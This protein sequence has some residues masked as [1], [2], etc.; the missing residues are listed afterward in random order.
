LIEELAMNKVICVRPESVGRVFVEMEGGRSG[1]FDVTPY[2]RGEFF[3]ELKNEAY[4][5][6]VR[7]FFRGIGWPNGQD[8]GPDTIAAELVE[9]DVM[10][11]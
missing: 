7:L 9:T 6:Q 8:L 2:M 5:C 4:F 3:G 10:S 11:A 1:L